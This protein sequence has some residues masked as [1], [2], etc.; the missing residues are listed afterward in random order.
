[1]KAIGDQFFDQ[2]Y[3]V[4]FPLDPAGSFSVDQSVSESVRECLARA[5]WYGALISLD[6]LAQVLSPD[7]RGRHFRLSFMLSPA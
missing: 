3:G 1:M 2:L 4:E 6:P 7:L 5:A